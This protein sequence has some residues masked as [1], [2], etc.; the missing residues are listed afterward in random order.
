MV[1]RHIIFHG[2]VYFVI[3]TGYLLLTMVTLSPRVWGYA[4]YSEEIKAKVPPQTAVEKRLAI[5]VG[6]PWFFF[7]FGYPIY[8]TY[9]LKLKMGGEIPFWVAL[10]NALVLV[11]LATFGDL[12]LLDWGIVSRITPRFVI[13]PGTD[14]SDYADFSHHYRA[15]ARAAPILLLLCVG[16]ATLVWAI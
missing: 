5:V 9:A 15:H 8:S 12:V 6:L 11:A 10:L 13:I 2:L 16:I 3:A 1:L 14:A 4:D 7:V